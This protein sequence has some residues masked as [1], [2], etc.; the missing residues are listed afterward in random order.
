MDSPLPETVTPVP[1]SGAEKEPAVIDSVSVSGSPSV[2]L[3]LIAAKFSAD[4][5]SSIT[6]N[7]VGAPLAVGKLLLA[8]IVRVAVADPAL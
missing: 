7:E 8:F 6:V 1:L 5:T 2:S 3:T 4:S